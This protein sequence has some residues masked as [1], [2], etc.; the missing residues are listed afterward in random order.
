M[1]S[2]PIESKMVVTNAPIYNVPEME[3]KE[4]LEQIQHDTAA[5]Q[6]KIGDEVNAR[7]AV[8]KVWNERWMEG[9]KQEADNRA[10]K[11]WQEKAAEEAWKV[12]AQKL[13][14]QVSGNIK[15]PGI[16]T[17]LDCQV[18]DKDVQWHKGLKAGSSK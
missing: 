7:L 13:S 2:L 12:E 4:A 1:S 11:E 3:C 18:L 14:Q 17:D 6:N 16:R 5:T 8:V 15:F 10:E 9:E